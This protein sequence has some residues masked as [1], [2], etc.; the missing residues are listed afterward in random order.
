MITLLNTESPLSSRSF[1]KSLGRPE[2]VLVL[3]E[4]AL[5]S[6]VGSCLRRFRGHQPASGSLPSIGGKR[7]KN[8][9][10]FFFDQL[11]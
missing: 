6:Q 3:P 8:Q 5:W 4:P 11:P 10:S 7:G 9:V 2:M 1:T